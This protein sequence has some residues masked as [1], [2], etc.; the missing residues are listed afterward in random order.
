MVWADTLWSMEQN[1]EPKHRLD[2]KVQLFFKQFKGRVDSSANGAAVTVTHGQ[3]KNEHKA[4]PPP[5]PKQKRDFSLSGYI[6]S[7]SN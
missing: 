4:S 1:G 6:K 5:N 2:K 3:N 7:N